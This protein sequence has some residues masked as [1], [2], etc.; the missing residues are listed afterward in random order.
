MNISCPI[1]TEIASV[2]F[3]F[4]EPHEVRKI[5]VKQIVN[6]T[7]FDTLGHPT[8][9]GLYD[10]ALGPYQ[11][12]Q[13]CTT[14]SQDHFKC[15]GHF[16]HIELP[17]PAYN[18]MFF[19]N[20]Y[21]V[22]RAK[23]SY[24]NFFRMNRTQM[25]KV[26]SKLTLLQHGLIR[27]AQALED[28]Y[29]R[30]APK[31][32]KGEADGEDETMEDR[33]E[34]DADI[35]TSVEE[36]EAQIDAFVK[37]S[38]EDKE[39]RKFASKDYKVT[40]INDM[41]KRVMLEFMKQC[42]AA[43]RC[44]NCAKI[45]PPIRRDGAAKLFQMPL[46]KK[47]QQQM[48]RRLEEHEKG[49]TPVTQRYLTP[50]E[51]RDQIK[52]LF[53]NEGDITTLLYGA[54]N[55]SVPSQIRR[56][57][58]HMFFIELLAVAPT[59]FRPP[60]VMGDKVFESP[61]NE[62]L[63][64]ILK[65]SHEV[66]DSSDSLQ[67]AQKE[68]EVDKAKVQRL[69]T[70]FVTS[71][72]TLQHA[73]NSFLDSTKN[74]AMLPQGKTHHPGIRQA[75]EKK[76]G[77]FRK[78]M[79]GKRVNY[80]ARSVI[81]PDPNIETSE[82]GI[83][84]VFAKK[85]TYPEPVTP[86][87][88]KE[89]R[90]A[91]INGPNKWPGAT[92]V[93]HE[94]QSIDVLANL[95]IESRIAL[96]NSLL[97]PQ[98][99]HTAQSGSNPYPTR[100][101]TINKK[102][103]RHLRNGDMVLLNRQPTLHK[104]SIM[105]HKARVLPGEKTIRMHYA[106]CNTYNADFDGDE[107]NIHFPQNE[108]ARAEASFIANT[109]NQYLVPTS[110]DPLRGLIQDHVVCGVW[111]TSRGTFFTKEEY[112]QLLYGSLRPE[113]DNT[114]NGTIMT[115]PPAVFK[116]VPLWTGKQ[117]ISTI[118]L[119]LTVGKPSLN[120]TSKA[121]VPGKLWGPDALDEATVLV[122]DGALVT[123]ILDKS[124]FGATAF[125]L[126]HSVY[127]LYGPESAGKLLSI[128]GRL[129]TKYVQFRGFTCRMDDLLLTE[130]GN[131]W[132]HD[133]MENGKGIGYEAHLE[134][135]GLEETAKTATKEKLAKEVA[136][137]DGKLAGLDNAMK[138]KVNKLTSSITEACLPNG[139]YRKFPDND[140]QMM[141]ISGAKGS[142]VNVTQISCLLG[143]QELEGRRVPLMVSGRSLPS[144]RPYDTSARAGGFVAGRF[145]TGIRPQEYYFHCMAGREGLI[146]T[147]VKTSRSGYLQRC[148][149]KH[150][151]GLRVHYDHTVRDADGSV[152][153]FH[154]GEDSLD[155]IKAKYLNQFSFSAHNF[156]TLSQ[157][158]N[159][160]AALDALE[161][162]EG[163]EYAKKALKKPNKYDP[164]LS[165]YNPGR[166][167]GVVSERFAIQM[168]N[169]ID[170]NPDKMPFSKSDAISPN[171]QRYANLSKNKFKA[172]MQLKYLHSLVEAGESVGLLAA[173]S[174]GEPSTQMTLNTFHFAGY[175]AAN[176][177]LGIP[178]LREIIMTAAKVLKTP[179]MLLPLKPNVTAEQAD[180]FRKIA[181]KLTLSQIV[182]DVSVTEATS[183]KS[184]EN[185][186]RRSKVYSIRL[187]LFSEQ[188]YLEEYRVQASRV[189]EVLA[190][191]F[192]KDLEELIRRDIKGARKAVKEDISKGSKMVHDKG[193]DSNADDSVN[194]TAGYE[195]DNGDGDATNQSMLQKTKQ[196][197]TYDGPDEEDVEDMKTVTALE[198]EEAELEEVAK[199]GD[200]EDEKPQKQQPIRSRFNDEELEDLALSRSAYVKRWS[201]D[202]VNGA[203]CE[204]DM[205]F[206]ADTKKILMVNLVEKA[207]GR[208]IVHE[209]KGIDRC[210][211]YANPTENDTQK[212]LQ[213]EGVNLRGMWAHSD[214]FEINEI[215]TNDIAAI[216]RTY[217]VEAARNSIIKEVASVFGVYG[218]KVDRR[219]LTVIADYMTF[220]GGFKPFSRIGIG[221]NTAP[222]LKM[223]FE[224][225][226]KFLTE[227]TLHGDFDTLDNP[228][229]RVVVGRVVEGG[230]G[231][232]DVLQPLTPIV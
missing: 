171:N 218:I 83:P 180:S 126:V 33:M 163:E 139:L 120:M 108:V 220:E 93:Q 103:F 182:D 44:G 90:Q 79:M 73:V 114:G 2:A 188:E 18:P 109:D 206:P 165:V 200:V 140:M 34:E 194:A 99:S 38:L 192:L 61:Q 21:A 149:I 40:V 132:R 95:S 4:Y 196:Q 72:I 96:A 107:M 204:I 66:R 78:H 28:L 181:S 214:L 75:L 32:S 195:S 199:A 168:K 186:Y 81:S 86:H 227:A 122:V 70:R 154:Y 27:E 216:L 151:E 144:F 110:G 128:L 92:H 191:T 121:K 87:N 119:N 14:C 31:G 64:D 82:I 146:D 20:L 229:S 49:S 104:P 67:E 159:P 166:H 170:K 124:Q 136:R 65:G 3:S 41:R 68:D 9:G 202:D 115:V 215:D 101:Q 141:T 54:R 148:L 177:T 221:S 167:L 190:T 46:T 117:I 156:E 47:D 169:Y 84:P 176:V 57:T 52:S 173:Q 203:W 30:S 100:T 23:C 226:C 198:N 24:C 45:S 50:Y 71:I 129:F 217:G 231:S 197:A 10:S 13:L 131:K 5:S 8:K 105:A 213:T 88:I 106:N 53:V 111:M 15:P 43:K 98:S 228:S 6:P 113:H 29:F 60:S 175:G 25:K 153:Q 1:G 155:V 12:N 172:L 39:A 102:V 212:R 80:A 142:N 157:K 145:L 58:Y 184:A 85:L 89:M 36:Y 16:G 143:Q 160:K 48:N 193:E 211:E 208:V 185:G 130:E 147:A 178:R 118:L 205:T 51:V 62:L 17:I 134:Y 59:R 189:K 77:L 225:T 42:L 207:C 76:E 152:L 35:A 74:P 11:K 26:V 232:F 137:D 179:T 224:S 133:F 164:A 223:S 56:A 37:K 112:H 22:L 161:T 63:G 219:H 125:G 209:I 138:A 135:L 230:T 123:G 69:Q 158:Y 116:P 94:D 174:V 183:A 222:F 91:V 19:D 97:A 55:P 162:R 210:F 127:E 150:L 187:N 7:L 201:F